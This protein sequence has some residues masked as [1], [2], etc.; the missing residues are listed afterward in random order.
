[1]GLSARI[2]NELDRLAATS[3]GNGT[4]KLH[5]EGGQLCAGFAAV[6]K[7]ACALEEFRYSITQ[8]AESTVED[9]RQRATKLAAKLSYLLEAISPIEIDNESCVIQMRSNPPEK[10]DDGSKYYELVVGRD[11]TRLSR[12]HKSAGQPR[13]MVP[14]TITREVMVRLATDITAPDA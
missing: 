3:P 12:Y 5:V 8:L 9:L 6:D 2:E 13:Q 14:A 11:E 4:L 7:L 1:M 10:D